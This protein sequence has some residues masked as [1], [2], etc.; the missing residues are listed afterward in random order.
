MESEEIIYQKVYVSP[1][2]PPNIS[3]TDNWMI[4]L[5]SEVAGSSKETQRI[6]PKPKTQVSRTGRPVGG[7]ESTKDIEKG[8]LFDHEDVKHSTR[9][10]RPVCGSESTQ[11]CVLMRTQ[12]EEDQTRTERPVNAE[13]HDIDF[14]VPG[15]SQSVV[16]KAEHLRVQELVEKR[17]SSSSRSISSRFGAE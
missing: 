5:S 11:S 17:K 14:K 3:Y 6:Q 2:P 13:E 9:T 15:L 16:K 8:T 1:R 7:Q 4:D 10:V 12:I